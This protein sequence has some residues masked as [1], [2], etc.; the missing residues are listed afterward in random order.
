MTDRIGFI[1]LGPM[2]SALVK[3]LCQAGAPPTIWNRDS[4]KAAPLAALGYRVARTPR[5][6][7][8]DCNVVLVCLSARRSIRW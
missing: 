7:A 3:R 6:L 2:G 4:S 1:G 5:E 8:N